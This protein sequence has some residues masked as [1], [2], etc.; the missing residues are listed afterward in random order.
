MWG[1][2]ASVG[3]LTAEI[4]V[5]NK[6]AVALAADSA[7]TIGTGGSAKIYNGF[8]KIF[9]LSECGSVAV[10]VY[11]GLDFMG[12]P[13]EVLIKDYRRRRQEKRFETL[14]QH[15]DDFRQY[16]ASYVSIGPADRFENAARI[17]V[18]Y[19]ASL[20]RRCDERWM[21]EARETGDWGRRPR[22]NILQLTL[23]EELQLLK[24][25][26]F[27]DN[28]LPRQPKPAD[29]YD[30]VIDQAMDIAFNGAT[31]GNR[32]VLKQI[33]RLKLIKGPLSSGRTGIV[34]AGFG[35]SDMCPSLEAIETDGIVF[36]RLKYVPTNS[37][38]IGRRGPQADIVGFAQSDMVGA[39]LNGV[40]PA[41]QAYT[42]N[43]VHKLFAQWIAQVA[44]A[45]DGA[46]QMQAGAKA[47][48]AMMDAV[49]RELGQTLSSYSQ[50]SFR[51]PILE[52]IRFMP[53]QELATLAA[54]LIDIDVTP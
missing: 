30:L 1:G 9:E 2:R 52:M 46:P 48:Q 54:S 23:K 19:F 3:R 20:A 26:A 49:E 36:D 24:G 12:L 6:S 38:D 40:D 27:N 33:G 44:K 28:F 7:G 10:M 4:A 50:K 31:A 29:V 39:F 35:D 53:N 41:Y 16:L 51:E 18:P 8:N 25:T 37:I 11:G 32:R 45:M 13:L 14:Q 42:M 5:L 43:T 34:V 17:L 47:F 22:G 21:E 15:A